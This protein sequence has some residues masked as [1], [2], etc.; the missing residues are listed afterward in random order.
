ML[1]KRQLKIL[2]EKQLFTYSIPILHTYLMVL[3]TMFTVD[4]NNLLKFALLNEMTNPSETHL[5]DSKKV[6]KTLRYFDG[7][8]LFCTVS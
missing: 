2:T 6:L 5:N 3:G 8:C 4:L 1:L 7:L